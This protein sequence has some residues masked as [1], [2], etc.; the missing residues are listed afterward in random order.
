MD[1]LRE[2]IRHLRRKGATY[3]DARHVAG[4]HET[5]SV[6]NMAV[7][8]IATRTSDGVG[9]RVLYEGSWGFASSGRLDP[10]S[11]LKT[12]DRAFA[13]AKSAQAFNKTQTR[14]AGVEPV[15]AAYMSPCQI[16]PF[17]VPLDK[18]LDYLF[19]ACQILKDHP[20]IKTAACHLDFYKTHKRFLNTEGSDI[21]QTLIESGAY[22]EAIAILGSEIQ[23]RS[24]PTAHHSQVAQAGYEYVKELDLIGG[25]EKTRT[26]AVALLRARECPYRQT[27]VLLEGSQ[28]A[29]Q[30]HES[31]GHP[32]E[33][34]RAFGEELAF[35]GSSF[36]TPEKLGKFR[37]GS[38]LVNIHADATCERGAGSFAYDDEG[39]PA[40][41]IPIVRQGIFCGYLSSRETAARLGKKSGGCMRAESWNVPPIV[42]MTNVNLEPGDA[43]LAELIADTKEGILLSTNRSWSI[44]DRRLNFQF[45]TEVAWQIRKGKICEIYKNPLYTGI[46]PEFWGSCSGIT[47]REGWKLWGVPNCAKGEPMQTAHVG[48]GASPARF[49]KV[50]VGRNR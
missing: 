18:K 21:T 24:Y 7:E 34:D 5:I 49:E 39:V 36:L 12:A 11:L 47:N 19:W 29:L 1:Q 40:Q 20:N 17:S 28:L 14:L 23:T 32:T 45:G 8:S 4:L 27:T 3:A 38:N 13:C 6:E 46:T 16:D 41:R 25:A 50:W 9:I 10:A 44:D 42:R 35:A 26:E 33:L 43:T 37:Y 2:V 31:C 15:K 22:L 30:L 48:H